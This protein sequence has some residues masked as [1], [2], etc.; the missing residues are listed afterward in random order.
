MFQHFPES[1]G[2]FTEEPIV[3]KIIFL[4]NYYRK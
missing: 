4:W 2:E 3:T 1:T